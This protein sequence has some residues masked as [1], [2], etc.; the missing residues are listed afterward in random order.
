MPRLIPIND[1]LKNPRS[2]CD[3]MDLDI[4]TDNYLKLR[5]IM[6]KMFFRE[7]PKHPQIFTLLFSRDDFA[8]KL[9]NSMVDSGIRNLG[10]VIF[11]EYTL[12]DAKNL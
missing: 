10:K 7:Y 11:V 12:E 4:M 6:N 3:G 1:V 2:W 9:I 5:P 8:D